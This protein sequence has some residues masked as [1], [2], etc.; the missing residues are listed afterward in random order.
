MKKIIRRTLLI[1]GIPILLIAI[2]V[3][4]AWLYR[5]QLAERVL[6]EINQKIEAD[7]SFSSYQLS[8]FRH[9][10]DMTLSVND[11][12]LVGRDAFVEDTLFS[13]GK[14]GVEVDLW[15]LFRPPFIVE[16][17]ELD[18]AKVLA[19]VLKDGR[20]NWNI[21]PEE[22]ES[23]Q[24][25][26]ENS[27]S[28]SF[29]VK[30]IQVEES[31]VIYSDDESEIYTQ[32]KQFSALFKTGDQDF[33]TSKIKVEKWDMDLFGYAIMQEL[34]A[35]WDA[36]LRFSLDSLGVQTGKNRLRLN[37]L[38]LSLSGGIAMPDTSILLD[39]YFD[40]GQS[41]FKDLLSI[42]PIVYRSDFDKLEAQGQLL[43]NGSVLGKYDAMH[44]PQ[45]MLNLA[46]SNGQI[47][48]PDL[49]KNIS[50][51]FLELAVNNL[52]GSV[53]GTVLSLKSLRAQLGKDPIDMTF[54]LE[55][56]ES[57]PFVKT[58]MNGKV[59]LGEWKAFLPL[60]KDE[61]LDGRLVAD[62]SFEGRVSDVE[63]KRYEKVKAKGSLTGEQIYYE[64]K[65]L[66]KTLEVKELNLDLNPE[67][68]NLQKL[69][70]KIGSSDMSVKGFLR[71][72][73]PWLFDKG[74]LLAQFSLESER[75]DLNEWRSEAE[76]E[77]KDKSE[78]EEASFIELPKNLEAV[79]QLKIDQLKY[80]KYDLR[81]LEGV[82]QIKDG[83][84][85]MDPLSFD[86]LGGSMKVVG[87]YDAS[88][89]K[90]KKPE[91][92]VDLRIED[93]ALDQTF[94]TFNTVQKLAPIAQRCS[95]VYS[96]KLQFKGVL[97]EALSPDLSTLQGLMHFQTEK[98]KIEQ[99]DVFKQV[100]RL[101]GST[102]FDSPTLSKVNALVEIRDGNL[103]VKPFTTRINEAELL[104]GGKQGLDGTLDY[105]LRVDLPSRVLQFEKTKVAQQ[106]FEL[107]LA[108]ATGIQWPEVL[109]F[110]AFIE[111]SLK[112]PKVSLNVE[113]QWL[114]TKDAL[115]QKAKDTALA[116]MEKQKADLIFK[117]EVQ[118]KML[119]DEA[120]KKGDALVL[121]AQKKAR[122]LQKRTEQQI[123]Q[124]H[125]EADR[126][127][128]E[129]IVKAGANPLKKLA[130]QE[131][132][133]LIK[134]EARKKAE[135]LKKESASQT[136]K[137]V[138]EAERKKTDLVQ[139][140]RKQGEKLIEE[141]RKTELPR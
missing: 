123:D 55:K 136:D 118:A 81:S 76:T 80:E 34:N 41:T 1:L 21:F 23:E 71:Q 54:Y 15:S 72:Y 51:L 73:L 99:A 116:E 105:E 107:P 46:V 133:E 19:K 16:S 11:L 110:D 112:Q 115:V 119:L 27:E 117:A 65:L 86:L 74:I 44:F 111:G 63:N 25:E 138:Q 48:W 31:K 109:Q 12:S 22:G 131:A 122:D 38:L 114:K 93:L 125:K 18:R 90:Q 85:R 103:E 59:N 127:A 39:V 98:L 29:E 108:K 104:F 96:A 26:S 92:D 139:Q 42:I 100:G 106:L 43:L 130:A 77:L 53:D 10:P 13:V 36:D 30:S 52:D 83:T 6:D 35:E 5:D 9:F 45:S 134:S 89:L 95:G 33:W 64:G 140:A 60:E 82:L 47:S 67:E 88:D 70:M 75:L 2:L 78:I 17:V 84:A 62:I 37:E 120:V 141:A 97:A 58:D 4:T 20:V 128:D 49:P 8:P 135:Q 79:A 132:A 3:L 50:K 32:L 113:D 91:I 56:P 69:D 87:S 126:K 94:Q 14:L 24:L 102:Y 61:K 137:I 28:L 68:L 129:L 57:D 124:L 101:T 66:E 40:S 121:E 7:V